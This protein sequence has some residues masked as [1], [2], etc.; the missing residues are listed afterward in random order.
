MGEGQLARAFPADRDPEGLGTRP[1]ARRIRRGRRLFPVR[2]RRRWRRC[3]D[4]TGLRRRRRPAAS[5]PPCDGPVRASSR[6]IR[7]SLAAATN[8][9]IAAD[10]M[11]RP[12][13]REIVRVVA[14]GLGSDRLVSSQGAHPSA[15][16]RRIPVRSA[17]S[18]RCGR[19]IFRSSGTG[20]PSSRFLENCER[21]SVELMNAAS[22]VVW[23]APATP[24]VRSAA[25]RAP[26]SHEAR[27]RFRI[28][29][30]SLAEPN[31]DLRI[32]QEIGKHPAISRWSQDRRRSRPT[33]QSSGLPGNPKPE[34]A[35][36]ASPS[37][38]PQGAES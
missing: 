38:R 19:R 35:A 3:R 8:A 16:S 12:D 23:P 5:S 13:V 21:I 28:V 9:M 25:W 7:P 10:L 14:I 11:D 33:A 32:L 17:S 34:P 30:Y 26:V 2:P 18:S 20:S 22:A 15:H 29:R 31:K 37:C 24:R 27:H 36:S 4:G 6:S 1:G